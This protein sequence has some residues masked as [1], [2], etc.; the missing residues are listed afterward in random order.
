MVK[1]KKV[2]VDPSKNQG[3]EVIFGLKCLIF[4]RLDAYITIVTKPRWHTFQLTLKNILPSN[5]V[6]DS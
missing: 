3:F 2:K 4:R 6:S 5:V 1:F